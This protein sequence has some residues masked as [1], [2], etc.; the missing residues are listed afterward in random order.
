ME[1]LKES[2]TNLA[3]LNVGLSDQ[4]KLL[5]EENSI[6]KRH[7][8]EPRQMLKSPI[9]PFK[10]E[11]QTNASYSRIADISKL[12]NKI[13]KFYTLSSSNE[14]LSPIEIISPK[15]Q[16]LAPSQSKIEFYLSL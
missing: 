6:L 8:N 2:N 9:K 1:L 12:M 14:P 7:L 4:L 10:S 15:T 5:K 11:N 16:N 13:M 3:A